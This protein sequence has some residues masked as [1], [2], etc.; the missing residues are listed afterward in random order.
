MYG[1]PG[2]I[3]AFGE[4]HTVR[5][6]GITRSQLR[7]WD[8]IGFYRPS[9]AEDNRRVAFSRVYS[10]RDIVSLRALNVLRNQYDVPLQHLRAVSQ[11]LNHLAE[12]MWTGIR[13]WVLNKKVVWQDPSTGLPQEVLSKQYVVPTLLME[14]VASD[15]KRDVATLNVRDASKRGKIEQSRFVNHNAPVL[16]GTRIPVA[17]IKRFSSAGYGAEEI[18]AEYPDLT[19]EDVAAALAYKLRSAA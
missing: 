15:T 14:T 18:L 13:L 3:A 16:A 5:L 11:K 17:A 8:R 19:V 10:F 9:Y 4:D 1:T 12:D 6:T 2:V 7:Y